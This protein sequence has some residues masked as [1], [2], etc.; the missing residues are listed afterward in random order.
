MIYLDSSALLKLIAEEAESAALV[1]WMGQHP[2]SLAVSSELAMVEVVRAVRRLAPEAEPEARTLVSQLDLV[3]LSSA[4]VAR[5]ADVGGP[6]LR[7]LDALHLA[8]ASA[9]RDALTFF[10][11]YDHRL[12][13]A[14]RAAGFDVLQ[15][16]AVSNDVRSDAQPARSA[17]RAARRSSS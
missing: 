16:G 13:S 1:E 6:M 14:A 5:A 2:G 10:V 4:V 7:T 15:P 17:T 9:V 12:A 3:P 8:S 11:V